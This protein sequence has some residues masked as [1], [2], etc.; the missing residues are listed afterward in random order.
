MGFTG[1][2]YERPRAQKSIILPTR[3]HI[4]PKWVSVLLH[5]RCLQERKLSFFHGFAVQEQKK[6]VIRAFSRRQHQKVVPTSEKVDDFHFSGKRRPPSVL[7]CT[8][9][10]GRRFFVSQTPSGRRKC[11]RFF[12]FSMRFRVFH[13]ENR[14]VAPKIENLNNFSHFREKVGVFTKLKQNVHFFHYFCSFSRKQLQKM[15]KR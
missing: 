6:P 1:A 3:D 14:K 7:Y 15:K 8:E 4:P 10:G 5:F 2:S 12:I 11:R 9:N 13:P